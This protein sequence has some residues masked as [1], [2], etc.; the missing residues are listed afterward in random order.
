V[1]QFKSFDLGASFF[2]IYQSMQGEFF[3]R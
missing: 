3:L 2:H 1:T